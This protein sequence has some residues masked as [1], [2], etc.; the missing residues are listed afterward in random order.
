MVETFKCGRVA[1]VDSGLCPGVGQVAIVLPHPHRKPAH[2][3]LVDFG[4]PRS[5]ALGAFTLRGQSGLKTGG[6]GL[7]L[8]AGGVP[9]QH[10]ARV[11][12]Q[13][14]VTSVCLVCVSPCTIGRMD[15][16]CT[17]GD[18]APACRGQHGRGPAVRVTCVC[19]CW[20][21]CV[22]HWGWIPRPHSCQAGALPLSHTQAL[23][24]TFNTVP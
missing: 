5:G 10:K 4:Q 14:G 3:P 9:A 17:V 20:C 11:R 21:V 1:G 24:F 23:T 12:S 22:W 19:L 2:R 8:S 7:W 15:G 13:Q 6:R 16:G 18:S